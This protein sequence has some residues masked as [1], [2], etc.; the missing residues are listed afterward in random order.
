VV[1]LVVLVLCALEAGRVG[2]KTW[3]AVFRWRKKTTIDQ[4]GRR[5]LKDERDARRPELIQ[6]AVFFLLAIFDIDA[7]CVVLPL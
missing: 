1:V 3:D 7:C 5:L 2:I 4:R 6:N